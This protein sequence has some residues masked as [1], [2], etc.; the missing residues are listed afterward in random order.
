MINRRRSFIIGIK[1]FSLSKEETLFIKKYK[2]WGIILFSRNIKNIEQLRNLTDNIKRI[3]NDHKFPILVDQEGGRVSRLNKILFTSIFSG[4][5]FGDIYKNNINNFSHHLDIYIDQVSYLLRK[6]GININTAPLIDLRKKK[7]SSVIGDRSFSGNPKIVRHI[8]KLFIEKFHKNKIAS[9]IKHIPGHGLA[10]KDSHLTTPY[11]YKDIKYLKKNDFYPFKNQKSLFAMTAH[12]IYQKIDPYNTATHS[13]KIIKLIRNEIKFKN[14]I[15]SDDIS[16]K[17]LKYSISEN[18][19]KAFN[20]GCNLVLH[21]NA[22]MSEMILVAKNSP[23]I[24]NFLLKKTQK[25]YKLAKLN[26]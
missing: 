5:Y 21:C 15:I 6:V 4:E 26:E 2:P 12:I 11:I 23:V 9:V 24:D 19:K 10:K 3:N 1:G 25:F 17:A 13:K 16:M 8:G 22:K 7:A 20:A 14:I 18:T